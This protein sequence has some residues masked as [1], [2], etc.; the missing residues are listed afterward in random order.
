MDDLWCMEE[1]VLVWIG[2][3]SGMWDIVNVV[4]SHLCYGNLWRMLENNEMEVV[5][6]GF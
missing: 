2:M 1:G 5:E 6:I 3:E 4:C